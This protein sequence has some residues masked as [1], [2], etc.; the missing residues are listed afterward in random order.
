MAV[1]LIDQVSCKKYYV[2]VA[3]Q[4]EGFGLDSNNSINI[5][6]HPVKNTNRF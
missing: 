1:C 4:A 6:M 3:S 2:Q 5:P